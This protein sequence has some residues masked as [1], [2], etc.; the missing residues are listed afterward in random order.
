MKMLWVHLAVALLFALLGFV[1]LRGKGAALIAGY[2]TA[3]EEE[4]LEI[5]EKKLCRFMGKLMFALAGCWLIAASGEV[6]HTK[7]L[8]WLGITLFLV[9]VIGGVI[10]ANTG[11]RFEKK[12]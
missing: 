4:R 10:Y 2:N 9:A 8:F 5:D 12:W 3:S 11:H 6:F 1:F 7:A